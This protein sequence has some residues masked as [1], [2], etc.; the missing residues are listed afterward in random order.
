MVVQHE[1]MEDYAAVTF[2]TY[3][4]ST[5]VQIC[6]LGI[7]S[8]GS[9]TYSRVSGRSSMICSRVSTSSA[10]TTHP[11][12]TSSGLVSFWFILFTWCREGK[13]CLEGG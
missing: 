12:A 7:Q 9:Q 1:G 3:L 2:P 6:L 11:P 13:G 10:S 8:T 5:I 4:Q